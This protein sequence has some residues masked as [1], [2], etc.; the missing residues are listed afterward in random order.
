MNFLKRLTG[1]ERVRFLLVGVFNTGFGFAI[2]SLFTYILKSFEYG[3][4][5]ALVISQILA[6]VVAFWLHK[7]VTFKA[8]GHL[9]RDFVRFAMVNSVSYV[10]N[11]ITLPVLVH[12]FDW[13]PYVG[14]FSLLLITT[15]ISF[16]G[17]KYFSF[18]R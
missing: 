12:G 6:T 13:N 1:D 9:I 14:Q 7:T 8:P 11:L 18:K 10:I 4:M 5:V 2:F 17:H 3:Y 15:L 16:V